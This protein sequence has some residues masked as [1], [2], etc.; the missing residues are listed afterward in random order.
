M[1]LSFMTLGCPDWDLDTVCRRAREY[2]Y[3]GVDF[4]GLK[5]EARDISLS[6]EFKAGL[7]ESLKK[8]SDH[9]LE[10]SGISSN[11][12]LCDEAKREENREAAKRLIP[13]AKSLDCK[14]IRAF[15]N[16][17]TKSRSREE[18]VK[19]G[20][21]MMEEILSLDGANNLIWLLETHDQWIE[22]ENCLLLINQVRSK[23]FG[24]LWDM[25][26]TARMGNETPSQTLNCLGDH[27]QYLHVKD[28]IKDPSLPNAMPGGWH[29]VVPGTGILPIQ[30]GIQLMRKR[31]YDG[32]LTFEFEKRWQRHLPEPEEVFPQFVTWA[33]KAWDMSVTVPA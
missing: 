8:L 33:R 7:S 30:E 25:G 20:K 26:H 2:G 1:K 12:S 4:R 6:P 13:L 29:Y 16:G 9:G 27:I 15:G 32:W 5:N 14:F 23:N 21:S 17:D 18:L 22:S 10:V 28:A 11:I 31:G 19:I 3:D 24:I